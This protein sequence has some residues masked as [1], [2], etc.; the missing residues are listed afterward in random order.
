MSL[1]FEFV[2][3]HIRC[4]KRSRKVYSIVFF[5]VI[6]LLFNYAGINAIRNVM[7]KSAKEVVTGDFLICNKNYT[8]SLIT[9]KTEV[10]SYLQNASNLVNELSKLKNVDKIRKRINSNAVVSI[11]ENTYDYINLIGLEL[12]E[13]NIE[14]I[15]G[16]KFDSK[17]QLLITKSLSEE[18]DIAIGDELVLNV[19][20]AVPAEFNLT[21]KVTGIY[22]NDCF[23]FMRSNHVLM[24]LKNLQRIIGEKDSVT[25]CMVYLN[26]G[27]DNAI[28]DQLAKKYTNL[29]FMSSRE[30]GD[31]IY[32]IQD[33]MQ[34]VMKGLVVI[35]MV[36]AMVI[37]SNL[38]LSY[39][40]QQEKEIMILNAMGV[41]H[42]KIYSI[43]I[44]ESL[45][46]SI[47]LSAL[48]VIMSI[49]FVAILGNK[50][51]PIG[52][53]QKLF[54]D[55]VLIL[56]LQGKQIIGTCIL[57]ICS[58]FVATV[59]SLSIILRRIRISILE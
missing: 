41:S 19:S 48:A 17:D 4:N 30:S 37:V 2:I 49:V 46:Q 8:F 57:I 27:K 11:N 39:L 53:A 59:S 16:K 54:G 7:T 20:N 13:E 55:N 52:G 38:A 23:G 14:V 12:D 36:I 9:S 44:F 58:A 43:Y 1:I 34:I 22:D 47:L 32:S 42:A 10:P 45:I 3:Q 21:C 35:M 5:V 29:K 56:S 51:I 31:L 26:D 6:I 24:D 33:G 28:C 15:E 18:Y 40:K 25:H 50:G